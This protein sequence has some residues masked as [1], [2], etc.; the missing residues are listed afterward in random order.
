[1]SDTKALFD[2]LRAAADPQVVAAI[3]S[4]VN[5]GS[6]RDLCRVN[7]LGFAAKHGLDQER[8]IGAF[9]HA[10]GWACSS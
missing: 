7:V 4:L 2:T 10:A 9:L 1:M 8:T 5:E 6:D 3:A